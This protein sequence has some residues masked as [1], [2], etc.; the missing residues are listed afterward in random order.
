MLG[1]QSQDY[2]KGLLAETWMLKVV[3]VRVR[4]K[5]E[6]SWRHSLFLGEYIINHGQNVGRQMDAEVHSGEVSDENEEHIIGNRRKAD[7]C[8]EMAKSLAESRS[9]ST[10]L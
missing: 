3:L 5:K 1:T 8:Y 2:C 9:C 4:K 6:E 7:L 10:V